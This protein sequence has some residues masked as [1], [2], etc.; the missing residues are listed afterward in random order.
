MQ[1]KINDLPQEEHTVARILA[2][3]DEIQ[4]HNVSYYEHDAPTI[5]DAEYDVLMRELR[6]LE[7]QHPELNSEDSPTQKVGGKAS[8]SF[9]PVKHNAPLLSLDN[10]F[11]EDELLKFC[12]GIQK[13]ASG[14]AVSFCCEPKYD[15]LAISITYVD[16]VYVQAAT[17][18]DGEVGEDVTENVRTITTVPKTLS[19]DHPG[20]LEV[21]GE[22]YMPHEVFKALNDKL[23]A[24]GQ[25]PFVN[26]RNAAAGSLRQID[27]ARVAERGLAFMPYGVI[28]NQ[29]EFQ[30]GQYESLAALA[31]YGFKIPELTIDVMLLSGNTDAGSCDYYNAMCAERT[32]LGYDIDG[33]VIKV[34]NYKLQEKLGYTSK[35]PKWAIAVKFPADTAI[36]KLTSVDY[37]VGRTGAVTP[38]AKIE[39]VFVGGVTVSSVTLHN[40]DE[41]ERL[42]LYIGDSVVVSRAGDVIPKINRC[43]PSDLPNRA[44]LKVVFPT[45]CPACASTLAEDAEVVVRRCVN[46]DCKEQVV[47]RLVH[48]VSRPAMDIDG[49]GEQTIRDLVEMGL[50]HPHELYELTKEQLLS[51]PRMAEKSA[52][53]LLTAIHATTVPKLE[54]FIFSLGIKDVGEST[55]RNL[56]LAFVDLPSLMAAS[57]EKLRKVKD[58]GE[59]A[60]SNIYNYF[61]D[62]EKKELVLKLRSKF[63]ALLVVR[64][65]QHNHFKDKTVVIT[66]TLS[67]SRDDI[68]SELLLA[69]AKV[70][71]SVSGKTDYLLAGENAGGKLDAAKK[72]GV[73][74]ISEED[75][76]KLFYSK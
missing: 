67:R 18:G 64:P 48:Y 69:G 3:R 60:S 15:G 45:N 1:N 54:N 33:V 32:S 46:P 44:E 68:K 10:A 39:P 72:H 30:I 13:E 58:I 4:K 9:A 22:V 55:A 24:G 11:N 2:L 40:A 5:S 12:K 71:G 75:Y 66:G 23:Q 70:S 43:I 47:Q 52:T 7:A 51:L 25:K 65:L 50:K 6:A 76:S 62:E 14:E 35:F 17:R 59:V 56:T 73:K 63:S 19:K 8:N 21:R 57:K 29:P 34:N 49:L 61:H 42:G 74:I 20:M 27:P 28:S 31:P 16:G 41:I 26:P 53:K 37:Q 38:V 36:T